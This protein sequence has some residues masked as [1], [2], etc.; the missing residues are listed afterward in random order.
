M[1][2]PWLGFGGGF[3]CDISAVG[4]GMWGPGSTVDIRGLGSTPHLHH[5]HH[6]VPNAATATVLGCS[7]R[8]GDTPGSAREATLV[9][10]FGDIN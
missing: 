8:Q 1:H 10:G 4:W 5:C 6:S 3:L 9:T 7:P 2:M